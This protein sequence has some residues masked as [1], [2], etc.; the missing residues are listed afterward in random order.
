MTGGAALNAWALAWETAL[1]AWQ[2]SLRQHGAHVA[3]VT[4]AYASLGLLC[5]ARGHALRRGGDTGP[6]WTGAGAA[7]LLVALVGWFALDQLL[8]LMARVLASEAGW[9]GQRRLWQGVAIGVCASVALAAAARARPI[10]QRMEAPTR[11]AAAGLALVLAVALL[12]MVSLH[13]TDLWL[14]TR[15][16]GISVGR[17]IELIGLGGVGVGVTRTWP[18]RGH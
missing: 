11:W 5:L 9:Y 18:A 14:Q 7:L 13:A 1:P 4:A 10:L 2:A 16:V 3:L 12:R 6:A 17:W 15:L 8:V